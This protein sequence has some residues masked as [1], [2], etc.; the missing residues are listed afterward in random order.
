M[1]PERSEATDH[2]DRVVPFR[3]PG[4]PPTRGSWPRAPRKQ[5]SPSPVDDLAEYERDPDEDNYRHRMTVN[6][7]AF[8]AVV[9]LALAGAWLAFKL[10]E[11][12]KNQDCILSGR[13]NCMPIDMKADER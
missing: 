7:A 13:R 10:A 1:T 6:L 8:L 4:A 2:D 5:Q 12:R 11:M 9:V 3:R